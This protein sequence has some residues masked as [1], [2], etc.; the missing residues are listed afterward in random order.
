MLRDR[1]P[2]SL[3]GSYQRTRMSPA[4]LRVAD[5]YVRRLHDRARA[6]DAYHRYY[7]DFT[8]ALYRDMALWREAQLWK[9]DGDADRQCAR[10][11]TLVGDF[12]D[13]RYVPCAVDLCQGIRRPEKTHAPST[14]HPYILRDE[15][16]GE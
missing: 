7:A 4:L 12:P 10:L 1:E 8:T 2:T 3:V 11:A 5:L 16:K 9:E 14:C 15:P 6:R 13:S